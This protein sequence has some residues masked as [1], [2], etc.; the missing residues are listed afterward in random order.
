[1]RVS[2]TAAAP[3]S[4]SRMRFAYRLADI[5]RR[6]YWFFRRPTTR[7]VKCVIQ[8]ET[9]V[10]FIRNTYGHRRWTFPGGRVGRKESPE[11]A[12]RREAREEVGIVLGPLEFLGTYPNNRNFK[13]D[14]VY[15]YAA[16]VTDDAHEVDGREVGEASWF[17]LAELPEECA[18]SVT[19]V[20]WLLARAHR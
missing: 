2:P 11:A 15:C 19:Q 17:S 8:H 18:P 6:A 5:V 7:G 3:S 20:M 4:S 13:H 16:V 10:L 1:M 9:N 14:T 12:A